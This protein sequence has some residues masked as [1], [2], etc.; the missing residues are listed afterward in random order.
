MSS[1]PKKK[2][3]AASKDPKKF[4]Y[5][6]IYGSVFKDS[7]VNGLIILAAVQEIS[8]SHYNIKKLMDLC[9]LTVAEIGREWM[10]T[11]N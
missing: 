11:G 2:A 4:S 8:E 9:G 10:N 7:G 6:D 1:P 5:A 3:A